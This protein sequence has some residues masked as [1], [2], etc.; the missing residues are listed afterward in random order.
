MGN[1][2]PKKYEKGDSAP[3]LHILAKIATV[4]EA[5]ADDFVFGEG[6][7]IAAKK[8]DHEILKRFEMIGQ[9]PER[10]RDAILVV[11][12]SIIA[13]HKLREVIGS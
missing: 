13:K 10:E 2:D 9:L 11:L 5:S 8:L 6:K 7:S 3:N 1:P 4:F 12:D